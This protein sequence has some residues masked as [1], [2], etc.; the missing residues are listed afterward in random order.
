VVPEQ[1]L[2]ILEERDPILIAEPAGL[3]ELE[4]AAVPNCY[5][6]WKVELELEP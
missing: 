6:R 4:L 2:G 3:E 5:P 1:V